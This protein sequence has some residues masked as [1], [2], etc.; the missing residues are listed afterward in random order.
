M[1]YRTRRQQP[2]KVKNK[3]PA[4]VQITAEQLLKEAHDRADPVVFRPKQKISDAEEL[5]EYRLNK[6]RGFEEAIRRNRHHFSHWLKYAAWEEDQKEYD[7]ARS[8][9]ERVLEID[10]RNPALWTRYVEMEMR[11]Q[12]VNLARNLWDRMCHLLPRVDQFWYKYAYMEEMLNNIAGA[13]QVFEK[14]MVWKPSVEAWDSYAAFEIRYREIT[15]ARLVYKRMVESHP[16]PKNFIKFAKFEEQFNYKQRARSV[17]E[18]AVEFFKDEAKIYL[19]FAKFETRMKEIERA[20]A[21]YQYALKLNTHLVYQAYISFEKQYG[22]STV[23]QSIVADK[24]RLVYKEEI[25][26]N[27]LNYDAW[28][29]L[30][31]LEENLGHLERVRKTYE[32][33]L[34]N[35]P[36]KTKKLWSRY[37]YLY[38]FWAL[39]EESVCSDRANL[40]FEKCLEEIPKEFTFAKVWILYAQLKLRQKNVEEARNVFELGLSNPKQKLFKGY[41]DFEKQLFEFERVRCLYERYLECF[42]QS[43]YAWVEYAK[44]E[45]SLRDVV[46]ARSIFELALNFVPVWMDYIALEQKEC[47]WNNVRNLYNRMEKTATVLSSLA[48]FELNALDNPPMLRLERSRQVLKNGF[49][50]LKEKPEERVEILQSWYELEEEKGTMESLLEVKNMFPR[51]VE[52][53]KTLDSKVYR[54]YLF[55]NDEQKSIFTMAREWK[56]RNN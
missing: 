23:L 34:S 2:T 25:K 8:I 54:E 12:N 36:P 11:L 39:F 50:E 27:P 37:I 46:R 35:P 6:R 51:I 18:S 45:Y 53:R 48:K 14:W 43:E 15:R 41:I 20:R 47:E 1:S 28:F 3:T 56:K 10:S 33:A 16:E 30:V 38:L 21:I 24:R 55:P 49:L 9:F 31:M 22:D 5:K 13:R 42:P 17:Y 32:E 4:E 52:K 7:R 29:D 19:S 26:S 44:M 40:V